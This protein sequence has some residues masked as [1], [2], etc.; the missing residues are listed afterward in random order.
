MH[1]EDKG[2]SVR[3]YQSLMNGSS[4]GDSWQLPNNDYSNNA[5]KIVVVLKWLMYKF[6]MSPPLVMCNPFPGF[7]F[8]SCMDLWRT[9]TRGVGS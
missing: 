9:P 4:V 1:V 5:K 2:A 7:C 6:K 3:G 8:Q